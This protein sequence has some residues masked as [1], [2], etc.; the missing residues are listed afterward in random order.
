MMYAYNTI[1]CH[2]EADWPN[3]ELGCDIAAALA[4]AAGPHRVLRPTMILATSAACKALELELDEVG[5]HCI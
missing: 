2:D 5:N 3:L 4:E 1:D